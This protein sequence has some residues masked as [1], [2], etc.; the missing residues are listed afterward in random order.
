MQPLPNIEVLTFLNWIDI[1]GY[2][3]NKIGV[4]LDELFLNDKYQEQAASLEREYMQSRSSDSS[5]ERAAHERYVDCF[6]SELKYHI[7]EEYDRNPSRYGR[8]G[9]RR[10]SDCDRISP[11][12]SD[13][14]H[15]LR[16]ID[17]YDW[18]QHMDDSP[19]DWYHNGDLSDSIRNYLQSE[20]CADR[21]IHGYFIRQTD[22]VAKTALRFL[23]WA[24]NKRKLRNIS[25]R[26][27]PASVLEAYIHD[28]VW[29]EYMHRGLSYTEKSKKEKLLQRV[30]IQ[31][32]YDG[33][34][35]NILTESNRVDYNLEAVVR[36]SFNRYA[37][38]KC[39]LLAEDD[40][41]HTLV[42]DYWDELNSCSGN[43]LDIYYSES[44]L[45]Q[46]GRSTADKLRIRAR[47]S[48][49]P[50]IFLWEYSLNEGLSIPVG[51]LDSGELV[52]L[53]KM[54]TDDIAK[55]QPLASVAE[56]AKQVVEMLV[57]AKNASMARE[58]TFTKHLLDACIKLQNNENYVRNTDENGRNT[59]LRDLLTTAGYQVNDQSLSGLS[60][61]AKSSGEVDL[62]VYDPDGRPFTIAESLNITAVHPCNW[63]RK[64]F[65]KHVNKLY[66]YDANGLP[67]NYVIV[68]ATTPDFARFTEEV[69]KQIGSPNKCPYGEAEL[70]GVK[71][72]ETGFS[73]LSMA[74][75]KYLRNGRETRLY[76]ICVRLA[77]KK[78]DVSATK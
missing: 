53:F 30:L 43:Y 55:E 51:G 73:D 50:S 68:Y 2:A 35:Q 24:Q 28:H 66:T 78:A 27:I 23:E 63:D 7:M 11:F 8:F 16:S 3:R 47:V 40:T 31:Q 67:R 74:C 9:Y 61:T 72:I 26:N 56:S 65:R 57:A 20:Y 4:P 32:E 39:T 36:R 17:P 44:E 69:H 37:R 1:N 54:I 13:L 14:E 22:S 70:V 48:A 6:L 76:V 46:R 60:P 52:D 45:E 18:D 25:L 75:A 34:L 12:S 71:P 64:N 29:N 33:Y 38:Y 62:K 19:M 10:D 49:Y 59:Y 5:S 21:A 58:D 77:D 15:A 41:F 42:R